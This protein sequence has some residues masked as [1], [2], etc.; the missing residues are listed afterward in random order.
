MSHPP[1][2]PVLILLITDSTYMK[3]GLID[4]SPPFCFYTGNQSNTGAAAEHMLHCIC[5]GFISQ[6]IDKLHMMFT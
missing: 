4:M 3:K 6:S 2:G 5:I 1:A